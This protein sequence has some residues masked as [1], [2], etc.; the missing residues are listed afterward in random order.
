MIADRIL[1]LREAAQW[2]Q[3]DLAK[4]LHISCKA[5]KNWEAGISE[6][7]AKHIRLLAE[8]FHVSADFLLELDTSEVININHL[9]K[10]N[11]QLIRTVTMLLSESDDNV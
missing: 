7:F 11:K 6:P 3:Q 2:S 4:H 10:K 8:L 9:S 1:Q 5:V